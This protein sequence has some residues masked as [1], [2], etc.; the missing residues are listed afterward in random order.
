MTQLTTPN[1]P[2]LAHIAHAIAAN[3]KLL[4]ATKAQYTRA[5]QAALDA[6]VN[7]YDALAVGRYAQSVLVTQTYLNIDLDLHD[8]ISD[9]VPL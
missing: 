6:G 3:G 4:P 8:T 2:T 9:Y 5:A 7:I 1:A